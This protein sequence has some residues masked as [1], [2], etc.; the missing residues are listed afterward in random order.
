MDW[1]AEILTYLPV[2]LVSAAL[3]L[4]VAFWIRGTWAVEEETETD[5]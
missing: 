1:L 2:V 3:I 4:K 5:D